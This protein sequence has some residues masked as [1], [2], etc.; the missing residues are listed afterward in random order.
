MKNVNQEFRRQKGG[1][2][3]YCLISMK[4][5]LAVI[6]ITSVLMGAALG[7]LVYFSSKTQSQ[8]QQQ[9]EQL[10]AEE[11][12]ILIE[13]KEKE[14]ISDLDVIPLYTQGESKNV[15]TFNTKSLDE[16]YQVENSRKVQ[17]VLQ[18]EFKRGS[19]RLDKALW[20]LN[21]Y[22][23]SPM[24]L[25]LYF[26]TR[27]NTYITYTVSV[28][29]PDIPNFH[30]TL[31]N[32]KQGNV[33]KEHEYQIVGLIPEMKNYI[34]IE[35]YSESD[36]LLDKQIYS[37]VMDDVPKGIETH[38]T[39]TKGVK[40]TEQTN[41]LY[42]ILGNDAAN[43]KMSKCLLMYDNSGY[44][45]GYIPLKGYRSDRLVFVDGNLLYSYS[46]QD[47]AL[48]SRTGQILNTYH[49]NGYTMHHD[50]SYDN[51]GN[52][53]I[54]ANDSRKG[55]KTEEDII[56]KLELDTRKV[57]KVLDMKT[58]L[59]EVKKAAKLT[60]GKKV[61]DWLHLN[62]IQM[63]SKN[64]CLVSSSEL[65][66]IIRIDRIGKNNP[67]IRYILADPRI[68]RTTK[69]KNKLYKK[70]DD[71]LS[72]FGQHTVTYEDS[73]ALSEGQ[74][75]IYM[76]NNNY[77][78][79]PTRPSFDWTYYQKQGVGTKKKSVKYSKFYKYLV[80]ETEKTYQLVKTLDVPYS[81]IEGSAQEY[82]SNTIINSGYAKVFGEYNAEGKLITEYKTNIKS[83]NYR[84][85]KYDLKSFL[86]Y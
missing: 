35:C 49:L 70:T 36:K 51:A 68:W 3:L 10:H 74:H 28:S 86:F 79:S 71:F 37:I 54:L 78:N 18:K 65:S 75:Y 67:K 62:T 56:L 20:A 46:K 81:S 55:A 13:G 21:P 27:E 31:Y 22:G 64:S 63:I 15:L 59:P 60:K 6:L 41:G 47:L 44:L 4:K 73:S 9:Q 83:Y 52:L 7:G 76:F 69:Q 45:R 53:Y 1:W 40:Q 43:K 38:L 24:S 48:V 32:G 12:D 33:T 11:L 72:Q 29:N 80:N 30:R 26:K 23:T 5:I 82:G 84:V 66:S 57:T 58:L 2:Q 25:Y 42:F 50:F 39:L 34:T 19:R 16:V 14:K 61:L 8:K 77:G 17:Q 85:F